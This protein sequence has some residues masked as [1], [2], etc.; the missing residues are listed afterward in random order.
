MVNKK[1]RVPGISVYPRRGKWAYLV[2]TEPDILTGKR[3]R[4]YEGGFETE[5]DAWDA[6]IKK[7]GELDRGRV[8]K[9]SGRTV[10]QFLTEWLAAIRHSVKKSTY[11]NYRT[12]Y[13]AYVKPMIGHRRLQ[14][15]SVPALN[16]FYVHLLESG[17]IKVDNNTKMY[18]FWKAHLH[19]HNGKGPTPT[20]ISAACG[21]TIHAAKAA[22]LR[23]R[24]G[25][26]PAN[27]GT[28]LSV[29]SVK[30]VH[31]LL[32]H[33]LGDAVAWQYIGMNPAEHARLPRE[34]RGS[35]TRR[36]QPWTVEEMAK[37]LGVAMTDRFAGM[38]VLAATSGMRRSELAGAERSRLDLD[39]GSLE[40][41]DTRV[42]I[43]GNV[44]DEDGKSEGS[45]RE[46]SL[47]PFTVAA[48]RKYL[49]MLD[50]E[51][52]EFGD[53]YVKDG[54]LMCWEDGTSLHPDTI[55]SRFNRLVDLAGVRRIRLHDIRHTYSTLALN[56]G[57]EPKIVSDRVGHAN[58]NVTFQ[59]YT[60]RSK[61]LDRPAA[62]RIAGLIEAAMQGAQAAEEADERAV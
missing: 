15:I 49:A 33:A 46:I 18:E 32:H 37:W 6:A 8:I 5:D 52:T 55:T 35:S 40:I 24:R 26:I 54:K 17:R 57:I 3:D 14:D 62:E 12:N 9:P 25:R 19:R 45:V 31:R 48:L 60:H 10:D 59:I 20:E 41:E 39:A 11:A 29:K 30:N 21:T 16:T 51:R 56:A 38:W 2:S 27:V 43:D 7:R 36:P 34:R 4:I 28:G 44:E 50:A 42:V 53:H 61:G 13:D 47:D 58:M 22:V 1:H 23:Y